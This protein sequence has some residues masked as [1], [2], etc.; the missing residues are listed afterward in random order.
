MTTFTYEIKDKFG[1]HARPAG[2]LVKLAQA[3]ES[4][5]TIEVNGK[6]ADFKK[7]FTVMRL[8]AKQGDSVKVTVEGPDEENAANSLKGF[9]KKN[10]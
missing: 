1:I 4:V 6:S 8:G 2:E 3:Y 7:L 10:L 5:C 9:L